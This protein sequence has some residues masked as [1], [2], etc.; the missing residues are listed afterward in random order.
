MNLKDFVQLEEASSVQRMQRNVSVDKYVDDLPKNVIGWHGQL[1]NKTPLPIGS[2]Y[3]LKG[4]TNWI[5]HIGTLQQAIER[6]AFM[7]RDTVEH[8]TPGEDED[9]PMI[10]VFNPPPENLGIRIYRLVVTPKIGD[11]PQE[12]DHAYEPG[13]EK[14]IG[15]RLNVAKDKF[16]ANTLAYSNRHE[17]RPD[18][19]EWKNI[20]LYTG[21][22]SE[23]VSIIQLPFELPFFSK[24]FKW[25]VERYAP[26]L[27]ERDYMQAFWNWY[28]SNDLK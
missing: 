9:G 27:L 1:T 10:P 26:H 14:N 15:T 2:E 23:T 5:L 21:T 6:V 12:D 16:G 25:L 24:K 11:I 4:K 3:P 13:H 19:R 20:S 17:G 22:P 28:F 18:D 7:M 8:Y